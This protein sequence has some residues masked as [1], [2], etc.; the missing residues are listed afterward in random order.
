MQVSSDDGASWTDATLGAD[1]GKY[2]FREWRLALNVTP[3]AHVLKVRATGVG[4]ETQPDAAL[5]N[6]RGYRR[7][8]IEAVRVTAS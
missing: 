6:P 3:G 7:N 4:G 2:A 5:W 8:V 1:F